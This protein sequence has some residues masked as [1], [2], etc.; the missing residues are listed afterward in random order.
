M[1]WCAA[2]IKGSDWKTTYIGRGLLQAAT[3]GDEAAY[4][5]AEAEIRRCWNIANEYDE[6]RSYSPKG[7]PMAQFDES[8]AKW[9]KNGREC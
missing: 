3:N 2:M 9:V 8:H 1:N 5:E 6:K 4:R 7:S